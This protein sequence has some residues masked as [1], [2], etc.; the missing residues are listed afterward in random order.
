MAMID[1]RDMLNHAYENAYAVGAFDI[2]SMEFME[3]VIRAAEQTRAP[4][5]L[6]LVE[7]QLSPLQFDML[8]PA[9]EKVARAANV[10]VAIHYDHGSSL[11]AITRGINAGCNGVM[12]DLSNAGI[13][14][15]LKLTRSVVEVAHA[16]GVPVEAELGVIP[17]ADDNEVV[18]CTDEQ[19]YT[20][21]EEA[22]G[23][24]NRTGIDF[25]AVS[26]GTVHGHSQ[27]K[28]KLD[29][30][31]LRQINEAVGIPLV[32]HGG[33]G[34]TDDQCRRLIAGGVS[35]INY[36]T[37]LADAAADNIRKQARKEGGYRH[38]TQGVTAAVMEEA[39]RCLRVWGSA[40]RAAEVMERCRAWENV[41]HAVLFNVEGMEEALV[42]Q[43]LEKGAFELQ[44]IPGVRD[45]F[46]GHALAGETGY[47]YCWRVWLTQP[48]A[49]ENYRKHDRYRRFNESLL[50]FSS[51]DRNTN[52]Y[53]HAS[54][55]EG[56]RQSSVQAGNSG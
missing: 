55:T 37:A 23:F 20:T 38:L 51:S 9:A 25:L 35:K 12:I 48:E 46:P 8:M 18:P 42:L 39:A 36:Y 43:T 2:V 44:A 27:G 7:S 21:V 5:I 4:V 41:E 15:N 14:E 17:A 52:T 3:G 33:T 16:C 13:E 56:V 32:I 29:Y 30:Q 45:I 26:V 34:L 28:V 31:R 19:H 11:D 47:R 1:M 6:N 49:L 24:V 10:P 22:R 53:I 40:G 54:D 50:R